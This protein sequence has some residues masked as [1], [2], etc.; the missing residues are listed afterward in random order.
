MITRELII[1]SAMKIFLSQGVKTV[2][3]DRLAKNLRTSKRTI[4]QHFEN[5][6]ELLKKLSFNHQRAESNLTYYNLNDTDDYTLDSSLTSAIDTIKSNASINALW[7]WFAI[8]ALV[9]LLIE[10]LLLKYLK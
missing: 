3:L 6:T 1:N 4:Y 2:P 10:M 5:K 9:F 7:K 8:F